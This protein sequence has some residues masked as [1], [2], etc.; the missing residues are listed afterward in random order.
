MAHQFSAS[1]GFFAP[2]RFEADIEDCIVDGEIPAAIHGTFYRSAADRRFPPLY[3][4][5]TPYNADGAVDMFRFY[6]GH[7][8]F[9]SRYVR[10]PRYIAERKAHRALFGLYRNRL[11]SDPSV[12]D[13]SHNTANTTPMVHGDLLFCMKEDSPPTA[14]DPHTLQTIGEWDFNGAMTAKTFT[15]HPEQ[16]PVTGELI[17]FAYEASGDCS[18]DLAVYIFDKDGKQTKE[19]RFRTPVVS[20]MHDMAITA[21]HIILPTTAMITSQ[22]RLQRGELHWAYDKNVPAYVAII[23]RN[24]DAGDVRWFKGNTNQ[25]MLIHTTNARTEGNK[26]ILDA[27]VAAGNF[28]PYFPNLDGSPIDPGAYA[29]TLRRWTF[30]LDSASDTWDEEILFDGMKVTSFVRM[31]DRYL[32]KA[33]RYSFMLMSDPS[34]PVAGEFADTLAVRVSNAIYRFDHVS[35]TIAKYSAGDAHGMSE[36]QFIPRSRNAAEGDGWLIA[37]VNNFREMK[38][39]VVIVDALDFAAGAIARIKLPFRLHMQVHGYWASAEQLQF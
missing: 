16:D 21:T 11:T 39:E 27:P 26:I 6:G 31:D 25:Q 33:F 1:G 12:R 37:A 23:P 13:F 15:A 18:D 35:G 28:H 19:I 30:D 5:D 34:L 9:R 4:H 22:E 2:M 10:T 29:P 38:S 14:V 20:M 3:P 24:G 8:D 36:P 32:T 17:A 7:V